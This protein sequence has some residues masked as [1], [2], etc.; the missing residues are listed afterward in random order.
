MAVQ[1]R[2]ALVGRRMRIAYHESFAGPS[3]PSQETFGASVGVRPIACER[4]DRSWE[5]AKK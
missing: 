3:D 4:A 5:G 2:G 1:K